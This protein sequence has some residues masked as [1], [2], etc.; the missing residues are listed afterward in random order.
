VSPVLVNTLNQKN[1][2]FF[3]QKLIYSAFL[4]FLCF[5]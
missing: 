2:L 3:T 4:L 1:M 5:F